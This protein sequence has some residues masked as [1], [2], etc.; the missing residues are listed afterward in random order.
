MI[1][2]AITAIFATILA[3]VLGSSLG[4]FGKIF[5]VPVDLKVEEL[6]AAMPGANCGACGFAGCGNYAEAIA[7]GNAETNA[8]PVGGAKVAAQ[9]AELM[10]K[11]GGAVIE[12]VSVLACQGSHTAA[13]LKGTYTGLETCRG[14]KLVG[15]T[16][17]CAW[18]C[19]GFGDC[20]KVCTF[21]ALEMGSDGLPK[22]IYANC[23]GCN[24]CIKECP[25]D[26]FRKIDKK[27]K[28]AMVLCGNKNPVKQGLI[29]TC[30]AA[31]IKCGACVKNCP[32]NCINLDT[33]IPV[34][35]YSK[36]NSCGACVEKC[37]TKTLKIIERDVFKPRG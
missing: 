25:Q 10:G 36:C 12:T 1:L 15:G 23:T 4:F 5:H 3:F 2:I 29:K 17:L 20:V 18:G 31:C 35:D 24:K 19:F 6:T 7:K 26:L 34:V 37:P 27:Q 33:Q 30:K 32:Q 11:S 16:K 9:L 28:G 21:D 8:C 22:V 13:P 14:A